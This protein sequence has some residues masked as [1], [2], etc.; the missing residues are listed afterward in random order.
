MKLSISI[1]SGNHGVFLK[2][3]GFAIKKAFD[4]NVLVTP[5]YGKPNPWIATEFV[6]VTSLRE[7]WRGYRKIILSKIANYDGVLINEE[8]PI[9][10]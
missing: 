6:N 7:F 4:N 1:D 8:Y 9:P 5:C 2:V 3:N 10:L